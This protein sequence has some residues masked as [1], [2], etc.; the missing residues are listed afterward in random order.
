MYRLF[1]QQWLLPP[2]AINYSELRCLSLGADVQLAQHY[3]F[4][5]ELHSFESALN[6]LEVVESIKGYTKLNIPYDE[7]ICDLN[8]LHPCG[9]DLDQ[10]VI[11]DFLPMINFNTIKNL[12]FESCASLANALP[13]LIAI[14]HKGARGHLIGLSSLEY[15]V[16]RSEIVDDDTLHVLKEF[17]QR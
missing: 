9:L 13:A 15:L 8:E 3:K 17:L 5:G 6:T 7:P 4:R 1:S 12:R 10:F 2:I 14:D 16:I 11:A